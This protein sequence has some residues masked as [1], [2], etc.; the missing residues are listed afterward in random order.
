MVSKNIK[1]PGLAHVIAPLTSSTEEGQSYL[2]HH[3]LAQCA[4]AIDE[5]R[6]SSSASRFFLQRRRTGEPSRAVDGSVRGH[7]RVVQNTR[8]VGL[9]GLYRFDPTC[10]GGGLSNR[11]ISVA[12]VRDTCYPK[13]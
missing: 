1:N 11:G 10:R 12:N 5:P 9:R 8:L 13:F 4:N 6:Q 3:A 7:L 2:S